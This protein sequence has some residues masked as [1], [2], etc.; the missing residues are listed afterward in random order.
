MLTSVQPCFAPVDVEVRRRRARGIRAALA[1][2]VHHTVLR[3]L[4]AV[5]G[6]LDAL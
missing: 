3:M 6:L 2:H 5:H 4:L 1:V